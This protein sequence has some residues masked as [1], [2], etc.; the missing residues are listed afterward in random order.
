M[1]HNFVSYLIVEFRKNNEFG[2]RSEFLQSVNLAE[3]LSSDENGNEGG[4]QAIA[5]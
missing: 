4:T 2:Y 5:N 3:L 1:K